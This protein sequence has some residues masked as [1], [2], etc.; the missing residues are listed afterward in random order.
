MK[1][2]RF[3]RSPRR[4]GRAATFQ[5]K[6]VRGA[7]PLWKLRRR[8]LVTARLERRGTDLLGRARPGSQNSNK[9]FSGEINGAAS[10][11]D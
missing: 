1:S 9:K 4:R 2:R 10:G 8:G 5:D 6:R 3:I 7:A 11:L